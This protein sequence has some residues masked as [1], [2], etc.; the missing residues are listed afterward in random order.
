MG[1]QFNLSKFTTPPALT[2]PLLRVRKVQLERSKNPR[3]IIQ[4]AGF[5][6]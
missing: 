3:A 5:S 6:V 2:L 1:I 4:L